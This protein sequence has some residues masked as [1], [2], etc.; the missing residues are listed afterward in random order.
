M[1]YALKIQ[2]EAVIDIQEAFE[3]YQ[4]KKAGLGF[5]FMEEI[6]TGFQKIAAQPHYYT[7]INQRFRR[8]KITRFSYMIVYEIEKSHI[9]IIA[10]RHG[11]RKSSF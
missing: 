1:D 8:F 6:E 3:W 10:V 2:S 5:E 4:M 7:S 11:R 9:I